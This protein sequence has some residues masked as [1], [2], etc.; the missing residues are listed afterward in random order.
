MLRF[1]LHP[2][3]GRK[4]AID[5]SRAYL[6]GMNEI[7]VSGTIRRTGSTLECD[8]A[9]AKAAAVNL[10]CETLEVGRLALSTCLLEQRD[11]PYR[12]ML[13]LA[14]HR[15][16]QF[17]AKAEDWQVWD[18]PAATDA[19]SLWNEARE[20]FTAAMTTADPSVS[21]AHAADAL[22]AGIRA[23]ERLALAYSQI[24]LHRRFGSR[25]ASKVVLGV[26]LDTNAVPTQFGK[27]IESFD[28][29]C[30]PLRWATLE[31]KPGVF[32]FSSLGPWIQWAQNRGT[33]LAAGPLVD[34]SPANLPSWI[35]AKR[36]S[37]DEL[38]EA[39]WKLARAV[40]DAIAG[41]VRMWSLAR[42]LNDSATWPLELPQMVELARRA[43]IGLREARKGVSTLLE[44]EHP[45]GHAVATR[46]RAV[47]P[48]VLVDTLVNEGVHLDCLTLR[49]LMG[50]PGPGH[51]TRDM[52]EVSAL[53]DSYIPIRKPV[54][55]ELGVPSAQ[56]DEAAGHWR[57]PWTPKSQAAWAARMFAVAMSKPH[58]EL[59]VWGA[60]KD[61]PAHSAAFGLASR[62]GS[63]KPV[64]TVLTR[65]RAALKQPLGPW[66]PAAISATSD[67][68]TRQVEERKEAS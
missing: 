41:H 8:L 2:G 51:L 17:I 24:L 49:L 64:V 47:T 32:D 31:P 28:M 48:R 37:F 22:V 50:D 65:A 21:E 10:E 29:V 45:F 39:V 38:R 15:I 5:A 61:D 12:L 9:N 56:V 63:P 18:H 3:R 42:G 20:H 59:V 14:R 68:Q 60:L 57:A 7:S 4:V 25:A 34:L 46:K 30:L 67:S 62:D 54:F 43:E 40:G 13:E 33:T 35:D 58:V 19:L 53:L 44:I 16:K 6:L 55:V 27:F 1:A 36:T 26:R 66:K 23:S 11:E 52:L